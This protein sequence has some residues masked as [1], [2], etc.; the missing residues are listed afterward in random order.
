V[1][2]KKNGL[3]LNDVHVQNLDYPDH[4]AALA[5]GKIDASITAEPQATEAVRAGSAVR[6]MG[7][8]A[9][10]PNQQLSVVNYGAE[11]LKRKEDAT[12][13]MRACIRASRFYYGA[14]KDGH[15]AGPN[16][17]EVIGIL[18]ETT[19][20]KDRDIYKT[21]H[22]SSVNPDGKLNVSSMRN[23]LAYFRDQGLVKGKVRVEDVVDESFVNA[24]LAQLGPYK[25]GSRA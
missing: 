1:L 4:V 3:T 24:A 13:F 9:W 25:K 10:Y 8:D 15:F 16:A 12:K 17:N 19:S 21:I 20:L 5:N 2:L 22:P 23:D 14:L 11:F 6:I 18:T 7:N